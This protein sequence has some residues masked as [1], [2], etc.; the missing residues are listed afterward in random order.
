L[1]NRRRRRSIRESLRD[2]DEEEEEEEAVDVH[3]CKPITVAV[4]V[5]PSLTSREWLSGIGSR[6]SEKDS[7]SSVS[8]RSWF[9]DDIESQSSSLLPSVPSKERIWLNSS[10]RFR[11]TA[12]PAHEPIEEKSFGVES[13]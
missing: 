11:L 1:L 8:S 4:D 9:S 13:I 7:C 2:D 10:M 12:A 3:G 6:I 5:V